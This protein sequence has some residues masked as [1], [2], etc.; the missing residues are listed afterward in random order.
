MSLCDLGSL[1]NNSG[2][3]SLHN[4]RMSTKGSREAQERVTSYVCVLEKISENVESG[5]IMKDRIRE[6]DK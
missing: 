4:D 6:D 1:R 5:S 2:L 3:R